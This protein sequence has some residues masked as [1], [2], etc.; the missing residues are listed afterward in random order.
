[1]KKCILVT[2]AQGLVASRCIELYK[3]REYLLTPDLTE[4][5]F[6]KP[7]QMEKYL[8]DEEISQVLNFAAFTDVA[9]G[10]SQRGDKE[11]M[12]WKIN[13]DG[14]RNLV[15][16]F[17]RKRV[18]FIHISTDMVFSGSDA[19]P[20]P[21][22][23]NRKVKDNPDTLTW[24]GYSKARGEEVVQ[25]YFKKPTVVRIIY[26]V[27]A[28][29][30]F[31]TDFLRNPLRLYQQ[32]KLYPLFDDQYL[33][34][35]DIDELSGMLNKLLENDNA[36]VFHCTSTDITTPYE[37]INYLIEAKYGVKNK[38]KRISVSKFLKNNDNRLRY[39]IYG[40]L[41]AVDTQKQ[42]NVRF[43]SWK[44]IVDKLIAQNIT[45]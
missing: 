39:P 14:V 38:V 19:D 17:D 11:G 9:A 18:R 41:K 24:Y 23:E 13:V 35:T 30:T 5:D 6:L 3:Q 32:R 43:S 37:I 16:M 27:R 40:G 31:K 36:G 15:K 4:F 45:P 29:F 22:E 2:G 21:Y 1:M 20:G 25:D 34:I 44:Q 33:S 42:L 7:T 26:P 10:E 28:K 8:K 12:C